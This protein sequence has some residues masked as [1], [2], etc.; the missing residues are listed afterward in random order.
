MPDFDGDGV[1]DWISFA[2]KDIVWVDINQYLS[3]VYS[4]EN[5]EQ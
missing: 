1:S 2:K 4:N 3:G 5:F